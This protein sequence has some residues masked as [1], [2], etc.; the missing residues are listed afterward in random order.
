[1]P[2]AARRDSSDHETARWRSSQQLPCAERHHPAAGDEDVIK[3]PDTEQLTGLDEAL[4]DGEILVAR[5]RVTGG[6]V[7]NEDDRGGRGGEGRV[8]YFA[9]MNH[10]R[11]EAADGDGL[12][13]H[14]L[15]PGVQEQHQ[16]VLA[17]LPLELSAKH[18]DHVVGPTDWPRLLAAVLPLGQLANV[19]K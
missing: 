5:L 8:E 11:I 15:M 2:P 9:W 16:E 4:G 13:G 17:L 14:H 12:L 7:V 18:R 3:D 19:H 1:M 10:R 6:M